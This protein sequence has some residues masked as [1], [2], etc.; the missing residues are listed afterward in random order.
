[1]LKRDPLSSP[2]VD[3]HGTPEQPAPEQGAR[4]DDSVN[5]E[6][7]RFFS[8]SSDMFA[9]FGLDGTFRRVNPAWQTVLGWSPED[10]IG[11]A[12]LD[13]VHPDDVDRT[14]AEFGRANAEGTATTT[15]VNRY[16]H[17]DGTYRWLDWTGRLIEDEGVHYSAARDITERRELE[18]ERDA[19]RMDAHRA[20]LAKS[21]FL[22]RMSHELRTP[23][24]AVLGFA[25]LLERDE[26]T[27]DQRENAGHIIRAGR[28]LLDLINEVLDISRIESGNLT[29]SLEPV[30]LDDLLADAAAL[31]VPLADAHT[32]T[33]HVDTSCRAHVLADRQRLRQVLLNLLSNAV[34]YNRDGGSVTVACMQSGAHRLRI[35]VTDTGYGI[36]DDLVGRLFRPFERLAASQS[37]V[38]GTGMGLALSKGLTEAMGGTIGVDST[39]DRGSTFWVELALVEEPTKA[40]DDAA[41]A[42]PVLAVPVGGRVRTVLHVE[43]NLSNLKL[44]ERILARRTDVELVSAMQG[45]LGLDLARTRVP[46]LVLLDLHLP[47]LSGGEILRRLRTYPE[48]RHIPVVIISADATKTQI[49]RLT[50][51]GAAGY[52][53]KPLDVAAFLD[54]IDRLFG[55]EPDQHS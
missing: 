24:N 50:A 29:I 54:L 47:D 19:A 3:P 8:L 23:L 49:A 5:V 38:E 28:H 30:A 45:Q 25:Q 43:D 18:D 9:V 14:I 36:P 48:T 15:F 35:A 16:R 40:L 26:L 1:M 10:L 12:F 32:I 42:A 6:L 34:K 39:L 41:V 27:D 11:R 22:S 2:A 52:L 7:D 53:T 21:E 20:N 46:D 17:Q 33:L 44:V 37:D 31:V 55:E 51:E 4:V 13:L